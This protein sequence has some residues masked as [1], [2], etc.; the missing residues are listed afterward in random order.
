MTIEERSQTFQ[1]QVTV[2]VDVP[3]DLH[4][5]II[6]HQGSTIHELTLKTH[7]KIEVPPQDSTETTIS[8]TGEP[9]SVASARKRILN[10]I[11]T[12]STVGDQYRAL[13]E[14]ATQQRNKYYE[15]ATNA[16][17]QGD[18][19]K[20]KKLSEWGH[21]E[22]VKIHQLNE[23]AEEQIFRERNDLLSDDEIDLHYLHKDEALNRLQSKL[24]HFLG[25]RLKVVTGAGH[26]S[27]HGPVLKGAVK[28]FLDER[29]YKYMEDGDGA[30]IVQCSGKDRQ[31]NMTNEADMDNVP[32]PS[33]FQRIIHRL[34]GCCG[35]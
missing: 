12:H 14:Q 17:N 24:E 16:Y 2:Y 31:K 4:G 1:G 20:A 35:V 29:H 18:K 32:Q 30:F 11:G 19:E 26:H 22:D 34:C 23:V 15:E 28:G 27:E 13:A 6:G 25:T 21:Q 33:L 5:K 7:A 8:I 10:L 3:K 9:L